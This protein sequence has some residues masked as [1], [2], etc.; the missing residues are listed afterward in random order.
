MVETKVA[1]ADKLLFALLKQ[2]PSQS[3]NIHLY[4]YIY[5]YIYMSGLVYCLD[6]FIV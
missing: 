1:G 2:L 4:T 5:T 6:N 3:I